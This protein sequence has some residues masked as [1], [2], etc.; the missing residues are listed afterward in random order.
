MDTNDAYRLARRT[1][2]E[3]GLYDWNFRFD[4][5]I[6]RFGL[7]SF[8]KKTISLSRKLT[9]LNPEDEVLDT[10]LHEVAHALAG[11]KAGHGPEWRRVARSIGCNANRVHEAVMPPQKWT[12]TCPN[13]SKTAQRSRKGKRPVACARCC[14]TFNGGK[15]DASFTLVWVDNALTRV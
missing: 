10:I 12:V 5:A 3:H 8:T 1:M 15:F 9:E 6:A 7:C 2:D 13:C 14:N 11:N 4:N